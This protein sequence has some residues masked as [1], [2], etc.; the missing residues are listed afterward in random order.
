MESL[1]GN[2]QLLL[3]GPDEPATVMADAELIARVFQNLLSNAL[4]FTPDEG[5]VTVSLEPGAEAARVLVQDTG[6]GIPR[7]YRER[8]FERFGQ[9]EGPAGR[10]R[11]STGIGLTFCK[12][13]IEAHGGQIGVDSEEGSG[14]TFWFA[15][16]RRESAPQQV[17]HGARAPEGRREATECQRLLSEREGS[18]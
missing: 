10:Q 13:A 17:P 18:W 6:P 9:V 2:R 15:L 12:L 11:H 5:Q 3:R 4:K 14:S 7:E 16:P 1:R 8:V